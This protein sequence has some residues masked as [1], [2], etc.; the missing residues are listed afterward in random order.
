[1]LGNRR[2]IGSKLKGFQVLTPCYWFTLLASTLFGH[3][4]VCVGVR[5]WLFPQATY[6]QPRIYTCHPSPFG[7]IIGASLPV[8]LVARWVCECRLRPVVFRDDL[9]TGTFAAD[10]CGEAGAW[11]ADGGSISRS[12]A[13]TPRVFGGRLGGVPGKAANSS[14]ES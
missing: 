2:A 14:K 9:L 6:C 1:M 5:R 4:V 11:R 8:S 7:A 10:L 3:L 13:G 12:K